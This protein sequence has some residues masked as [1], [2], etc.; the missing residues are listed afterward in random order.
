M[1][2][3]RRF[4]IYSPRESNRWWPGGQKR[5][6]RIIRTQRHASDE[7]DTLLRRIACGRTASSDSFGTKQLRHQWKFAGTGS[8]FHSPGD[9]CEA[10]EPVSDRP[11]S[12]SDWDDLLRGLLNGSENSKIEISASM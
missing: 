6:S 10:A 2:N 9:E 3:S 7:P 11:G 1:L 12:L 5:K 4:E 8:L